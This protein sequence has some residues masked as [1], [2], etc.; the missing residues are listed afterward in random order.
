MTT[1]LHHFNQLHEKYDQDAVFSG[2]EF[3]R[4]QASSPD[5]AGASPESVRSEVCQGPQKLT[6]KPKQ[7]YFHTPS[8]P[9][10][11][12]TSLYETDPSG[13]SS[14]GNANKFQQFSRT[15]VL[16]TPTRPSCEP[17]GCCTSSAPVYMTHHRF[18]G[19]SPLPISGRRP[20]LV[21][22]ECFHN[23]R[24]LEPRLN[25]VSAACRASWAGH[26]NFHC[27]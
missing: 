23:S 10:L 26:N 16:V 22:G 24:S 12:T 11:N 19:E 20:G 9:T 13:R 27:D 4:G 6:R 2:L 21:E 3:S 17:P 5:A 25:I 8:H 7:D 15:P 14:H 18:H 1:A